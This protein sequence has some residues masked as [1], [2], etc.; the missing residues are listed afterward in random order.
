M[1]ALED[2]ELDENDRVEAALDMLFLDPLEEFPSMEAA[3]A[4]LYWFLDGGQDRGNDKAGPRLVDWEHDWERIIAPVNRVLGQDARAVRYDRE[5]NTGGLH[6][7]TFLAAYM[8][9]GNDCLMAQIVSI[10]DKKKRGQKLDKSEREWARRNHSLVEI[11][12]KYT[13]AEKQIEKEWT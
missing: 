7:W 6:W 12:T 13:D 8:E 10:R 11:P 3:M 5:H 2:P 9:I 1:E 4:G